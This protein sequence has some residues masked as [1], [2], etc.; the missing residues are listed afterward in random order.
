MALPQGEYTSREVLQLKNEID[1][2]SSLN[3]QLNRETSQMEKKIKE[4]SDNHT[5]EVKR[6]Q[7]QMQRHD[8]EHAREVKNLKSVIQRRDKKIEELK[9]LSSSSS[10]S[11]SDDMDSADDDDDMIRDDAKDLLFFASDARA[12]S[13]KQ[14]LIARIEELQVKGNIQ[15]AAVLRRN[16]QI[17][18][19]KEELRQQRLSVEQEKGQMRAQLETLSTELQQEKARNAACDEQKGQLRGQLEQEQA[20]VAACEDENLRLRGQL[21]QEGS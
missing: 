12:A 6:L 1:R 9:A 13:E 5:R 4:M 19:L 17:T 10:S 16:E 11:S 21:E 3:S 2:L 18:K 7:R 8:Q 20:R 15:D 14:D